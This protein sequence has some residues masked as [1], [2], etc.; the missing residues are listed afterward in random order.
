MR[1]NLGFSRKK[2]NNFFFG[3][4]YLS[5]FGGALDIFNS[6]GT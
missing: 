1:E 2:I 5:S 6:L 4:S 3:K